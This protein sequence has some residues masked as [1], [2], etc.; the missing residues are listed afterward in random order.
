VDP[1]LT[2]PRRKPRRPV[3]GGLPYS[4]PLP[5]IDRERVKVP[6]FVWFVGAGVFTALALAAAGYALLAFWFNR[7]F[8]QT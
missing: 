8:G 1:H 2:I 6:N 4:S 7:V 5:I 3:A